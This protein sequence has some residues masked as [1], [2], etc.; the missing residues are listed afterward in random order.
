MPMSVP[1]TYLAPDFAVAPQLTPGQVAELATLGIR[2]VV[3]NRPENEAPGLPP[4]R[5]LREAAEGA[6]LEYA[7]QPVD[8]SR[9]TAEDVRDFA[10][11]LERLPRPMVAFCRSGNRSGRLYQAAIALLRK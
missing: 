8:S 9:I 5:A 2:S 3:N 6:K 4:E 11:L 10:A 1:L 7:Y